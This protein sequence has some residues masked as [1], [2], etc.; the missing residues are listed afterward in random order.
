MLLHRNISANMLEP[1]YPSMRMSPAA[2]EDL[3]SRMPLELGSN[4]SLRFGEQ[5]DIPG[6]MALF[7][8]IWN[9]ESF[10]VWFED[11]LSG[12]HPNAGFKD[13]TVVEETQ[14]GRIVSLIGLVSQTWNYGGIAFGC[15]QPETIVTYQDYRRKGLIGKQMEVIH[16]LSAARG[17][18]VQVIWGN[19]WYYR[20]FGYEYALEGLW[21]IHRVIRAHHIPSADDDNVAKCRIR[22]AGPED[23]A[24]IR[25]LHDTGMKRHII[26]VEKYDKDWEFQFEGWTKG[27]HPARE[28]R[29][30]ERPDA[31]PVGY[32]CFHDEAESGG[33]GVHLIELMPG[34][35]YLEF[36]PGVLRDLWDLA[37]QLNDDTPPADIKF[38]LG[39]EHP[40][41]EAFPRNDRLQKDQL[42]CLYIRVPDLVALLRHIAPA[43]EQ[44]LMVSSAAG[45]SGTLQITFFK[46]GLEI[47][48]E[49]GR[50][51]RIDPWRA[52][53]FWHMPAFPD[54]TILQL[55][56]GRRRCA[57]LEDIYVDCNVGQQPAAVL[58]ALFPPFKGTMWLGN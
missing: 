43:L 47:A 32:L 26:Q 57:E 24:F 45:F 27:A 56:F 38:Y 4:L 22:P 18:L 1:T 7:D 17:E 20:Q 42:E 40:A 33:F 29:I 25:R 23:Y 58:D 54:L 48:I 2:E 46:S 49:S 44:N 10:R 6:M 19:P 55:V 15:G 50:I 11:M 36:M 52:D 51:T 16:Q 28:W 31:T 14:T 9:R 21:D 37:T 53:S 12:Q 41:Y 39:S 13:F 34:L 35:G 3:R 30:I 8:G 5:K